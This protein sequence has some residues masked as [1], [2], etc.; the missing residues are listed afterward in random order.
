MSK[1]ET[2]SQDMIDRLIG[3]ERCYEMEINV[4]IIK[5]MVVSRRPSPVSIFDAS[6]INRIRGV[7][8]LP[9]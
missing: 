5:L 6:K 3:I 2:M 8:Q 9:G 1:L 7:F 4:Q